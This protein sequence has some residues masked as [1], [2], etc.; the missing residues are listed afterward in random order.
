M[1]R[2]N[3]L[4]SFLAL[5][6]WYEDSA[7]QSRFTDLPRIAQALENTIHVN[8]PEWVCHSIPPASVHDGAESDTVTL[9][10]WTAGRRNVRIAI[11]RHESEEEAIIELRRF[12][13]DKKT[14]NRYPGLGSEAYLWG[15]RGSIAFRHANLTVYV[16]AIVMPAGD[17]AETVGNGVREEREF[18]GQSERDEE[19]IVTRSFAQQVA[20]LLIAS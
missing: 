17:N 10:Q 18:A 15:I 5:L 3:I 8:R 16:T 4:F 2:A 12:A 19:A 13:A 11:V 7:A 9:R 20:A 1:K 14:T 6:C